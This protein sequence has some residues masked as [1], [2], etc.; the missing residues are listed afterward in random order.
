MKYFF[1]ILLVLLA[2]NLNA[3]CE[4]IIQE[5]STSNC[6]NNGTTFDTQDDFSDINFTILSPDGSLTYYVNNNGVVSGPYDYGVVNTIPMVASNVS[7]FMTFYDAIQPNCMNT[8][9]FTAAS[10]SPGCNMVV[11][12]LSDSCDDNGTP[13]QSGDDTHSITV[14]VTAGSGSATSYNVEFEGTVFGPFNYGTPSTVG[15]YSAI[16]TTGSF[17]SMFFY[18]TQ[19]GECNTTVDI[20]SPECQTCN[21]FFLYANAGECQDNG[22]PD[23][24]D[25][26]FFIVSINTF[27]IPFGTSGTYSLTDGTQTLGPFPY[28]TPTSIQLP[29]TNDDYTLTVF[30]TDN[31][32]CND[33]VVVSSQPCSQSTTDLLITQTIINET[34]FNSCDGSVI[35]Q[36]TGGTPPY[37]YLW[38][39]NTSNTNSN[40]NLCP[41][42]YILTVTDSNNQ[43]AESIFTLVGSEQVQVDVL[44]N[45]FDIYL[46]VTG[47]S[48]PY[49]FS[50]ENGFQGEDQQN[51]SPGIYQITIVDS[52]GCFDLVT[53]TVTDF[54]SYELTSSDQDCTGNGTATISNIS[55][56]LP[57]T[58]LWSDGS[59]LETLSAPAGNYYVTIT[60]SNDC[61]S[62]DSIAIEPPFDIA[63]A[64]TVTDCEENTGTAYVTI[65]NSVNNPIIEWSNGGTGYSQENL[66]VGGYSVT[67][68][69]G[70]NNC[71]HHENVI[72]ELDSSC[73]AKISG[74]VFNDDL[75]QTCMVNGS[76]FGIHNIM[77][78]LDNGD[79]TF[80][81][82]DGY[83]EFVVDPG[84]YEL[85]TISN[86]P[87][88]VDLCIDPIV[89]NVPNWGD[90]SEDNNFFLKYGDATDL[91]VK[92]IKG[93]AR[94]GMTQLVRVCAMNNGSFPMNGTVA[95]EH[96][97]LQTYSYSNPTESSYIEEEQKI[98]WN[99]TNLPAGGVFVF[100]T[101]LTLPTTTEIGT[102]LQFNF[103]ISPM[104]N[105]YNIENN[106]MA[107]TQLVTGSFDPNDKAVFP[108]GEGDLGMIS[109]DELQL[110]YTIRFQNTGNDT[111]FTVIIVDT[112]DANLEWGSIKP[113]P[114][115][116]PYGVTYIA[117][118]IVR[119]TFE[120][121]L[122]PDSTTN[123]EKSH[124]F[125]IFDIN[126]KSALL[127][128]T[129]IKNRAG[130][131]FD[132]NAPIITNTTLNTIEIIDAVHSP[133][134][135]FH[136]SLTPNPSDGMSTLFF[137]LPVSQKLSFDA[138]DINGK[139]VHQ[140]NDYEEFQAGKNT[141]DVHLSD[142]GLYFI[143]ARNEHGQ[144]V[145]RIRMV[146]F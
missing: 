44:Q 28:D 49:S 67:V 101:Y 113:K 40:V 7:Y 65:A 105:D 62:E 10:C 55:G 98:S 109:E 16:P 8:F 125:V 107:C 96:D 130:I 77:V 137:D 21:L 38:S 50:W 141:L 100:Y 121:I 94:P 146:V 90:V 136:L 119:F 143:V 117:Q 3:Q 20:Y 2:F 31:N 25:D 99:F 35:T 27:G 82:P 69:D 42:T 34:C 144:I 43:T 103:E 80:T 126:L 91:E 142:P 17:Q 97:P 54:L 112:L 61:S 71:S 74:Y 120:N 48:I 9:S 13:N 63:V 15:P 131:Y 95:M 92:V 140:V 46:T 5:V 115:D 123:E 52:N 22:T 78:L 58:Y 111:A 145:G 59:T 36:V 129:E 85:S 73:Y 32:S 138:I 19:I 135:V 26:D 12:Q 66:G 83:Y 84:T 72:V 110:S 1:P 11:E 45:C 41:G 133:E 29:A 139:L 64:S 114:S 106:S 81:A 86:E 87:Q 124:G 132:Y 68:T 116:K 51:L 75:V 24:E 88:Y 122:L 23:M 18:D 30:D 70:D 102:P 47:G 57:F 33:Q 128:G 89:V 4:V 60:D 108:A 56:N 14:N 104:A 39:D 53:V 76:T 79:M 127:P 134:E 6:N 118:N 37:T 93:N